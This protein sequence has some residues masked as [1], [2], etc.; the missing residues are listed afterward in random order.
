M[1]WHERVHADLPNVWL[2]SEVVAAT[3]EFVDRE[4]SRQ[5]Q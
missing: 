3:R 2:R 1:F 4:G 5:L